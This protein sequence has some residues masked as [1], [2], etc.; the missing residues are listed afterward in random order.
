MVIT[1]LSDSEHGVGALVWAPVI[2]WWQFVRLGVWAFRPFF[3]RL[4][5]RRSSML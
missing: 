2:R 5:G 3:G 1:V 4:E